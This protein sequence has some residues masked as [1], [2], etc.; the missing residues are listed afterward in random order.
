MKPSPIRAFEGGAE[1]RLAPTFRQDGGNP[2]RANFRG[3]GLP[4]LFGINAGFAL[5][6]AEAGRAGRRPVIRAWPSGNLG[7]RARFAAGVIIFSLFQSTRI[8]DA[9]AWAPVSRRLCSGFAL[10]LPPAAFVYLASA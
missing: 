7:I 4:A 10:D 5:G 8:R 2:D 6:P 1:A 9:R 3:R